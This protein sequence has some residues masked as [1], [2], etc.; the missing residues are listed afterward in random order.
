MFKYRLPSST[1]LFKKA[2]E[3]ELRNIRQQITESQDEGFRGLVARS[4]AAFRKFITTLGQPRFKFYPIITDNNTATR[5][6]YNET[7]KTIQG[8]LIAA[9]E[10]VSNL[11]FASIESFNIAQILAKELEVLAARAGSKAQDLAL[12][13]KQDSPNIL[14]AGDDFTS[15]NRVNNSYPHTMPKAYIDSRQGLVSLARTESKSVIDFDRT[16]IEVTPITPGINEKP[17]NYSS[18]LGRFY[19]GRFYALAGQAEPEG[20]RW[21]FEE[22]TATPADSGFYYTY[23]NYHSYN[24]GKSYVLAEYEYDGNENSVN[25]VGAYV[26][27]K[28]DIVIRNEV[29]IRDRGATDEEKNII[30]KRMIDGNPDTY[31]QCEYVLRPSTFGTTS[32]V[33]QDKR[34][35]NFTGQKSAGK[36]LGKAQ[37]EGNQTFQPGTTTDLRGTFVETGNE[38]DARLQVTPED[39]R[40]AAATFDNIDLDIQ[41]VIKLPEPVNINWLQL[42]PMNFGETAWLKITNIEVSDSRNGVW[43]QIPSFS[44]SYS[45]NILTED[46]NSELTSDNVEAI[47]APNKYAYRG[48]G[49]W[50]FPTRMV[51]AIR[52]TISQTTPTPVLYQKIRVQMHRIWEKL[53]EQAYDSTSRSLRSNLTKKA[54]WTK[55]ITLDY[56]R[57]VQILQ[58]ELSAEEIAP[59]TDSE[60]TVTRRGKKDLSSDNWFDSLTGKVLSVAT[61][62]FGL[63]LK[64]LGLGGGHERRSS[65]SSETSDTGYY[66]TGY[67][68][69]TFYDLIG[70]RIGIREIDA[71]FNVYQ[72]T[73]ELISTPFY[74]PVDL[75]EITLRVSDETPEGTSIEYFIS[76]DDGKNWYRLNPL[77]KPSIYGD[78]GFAVPK[79]IGFN[80]PGNPANETKYVTTNAPVRKIMFKAILKSDNEVNSPILKSYR[81][82]MY[83]ADGY[84]P[85]EFET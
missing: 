51:Q 68:T 50:T 26:D 58:G 77:D 53:Y 30:R 27:D 1:G 84:R 83:P 22:L 61:S 59:K 49:V 11:S 62:G 44:G 25:P 43:S 8:D 34:W 57:S 6:Y 12:I 67:W 70:Y 76:P 65:Y 7:R 29:I 15:R 10:D 79:T 28:G 80:L 56:L 3:F 75:K 74:S 73:S 37:S 52:Y 14:V 20:G 69:E 85:T 41:I 24:G 18:N 23:E 78:D 4:M 45:Q 48:S 40:A 21:H 33:L 16:E 47:M 55:V 54:E 9:E 42:N 46:V 60:P 32:P 35:A 39:L 31:W 36:A 66:M 72:L 64:V 13:S 81:L 82:L 38:D 17:A 19:E 63:V 5:E 71:F 2:L